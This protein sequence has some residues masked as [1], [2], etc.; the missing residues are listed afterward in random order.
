[1]TQSRKYK[2]LY[3]WNIWFFAFA[4]FYM[5]KYVKM[6]TCVW[7]RPCRQLP[8]PLFSYRF[9]FTSIKRAIY[10]IQRDNLLL[11]AHLCIIILMW[12]QSNWRYKNKCCKII[13]KIKHNW[14]WMG[15]VAQWQS[16]MVNLAKIKANIAIIT[17]TQTKSLNLWVYRI[18]NAR[19]KYQL[20][21]SW[22]LFRHFWRI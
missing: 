9:H 10:S 7:I 5:H 15:T 22:W 13:K 21:I 14:L 16:L 8:T 2:Y 20:N 19:L 6:C 4:H 3:A 12:K 1:M 17:F 18:Y 11:H